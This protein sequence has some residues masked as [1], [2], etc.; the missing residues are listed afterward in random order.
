MYL[1]AAFSE[2]NISQKFPTKTSTVLNFY[3]NVQFLKKSLVI[4][5]CPFA[6]AAAYVMTLD[7]SE[8]TKEQ[9]YKFIQPWPH[10]DGAPKMVVELSGHR[11]II[12][13]PNLAHLL[14]L[15][16]HS[17][18]ENHHRFGRMVTTVDNKCVR[19]GPNMS[20]DGLDPWTLSVLIADTLAGQTKLGVI[21]CVFLALQDLWAD[22][23]L[24][25]GPRCRIQ[26]LQLLLL[27]IGLLKLLLLS[28]HFLASY[29]EPWSE[30]FQIL[31]GS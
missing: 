9:L 13:P 3:L 30:K 18:A 15:G 1:L 12:P 8:Q 31:S 16:Y 23:S 19:P 21:F 11:C 24:S 10:N 6:K 22:L 29:Q 7:P 20:F 5:H 4:Y 25:L 2:S 14:L 27:R 17:F 28:H 26:R